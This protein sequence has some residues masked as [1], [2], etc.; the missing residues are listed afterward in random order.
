M[1]AIGDLE[2]A[3]HHFCQSIITNHVLSA[4]ATDALE[5]TYAK[6]LQVKGLLKLTTE[7]GGVALFYEAARLACL[8]SAHY[9]PPMMRAAVSLLCN[10]GESAAVVAGGMGRRRHRCRV[11]ASMM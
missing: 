9:V 1:Q 8:L 6:Q 3:R 4:A 5:G 7:G 10:L 11:V 2:K